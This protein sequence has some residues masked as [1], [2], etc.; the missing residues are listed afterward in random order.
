MRN[1]DVSRVKMGST[2]IR[3]VK[4]EKGGMAQFFFGAKFGLKFWA[5]LILESG[6]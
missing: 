6:D 5:N 4:K 1:S 2:L 3:S